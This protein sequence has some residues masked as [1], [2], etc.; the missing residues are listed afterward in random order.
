MIFDFYIKDNKIDGLKSVSRYFIET[1]LIIE[2]F[3]NSKIV[4]RQI[5]LCFIGRQQCKKQQEIIHC[6]IPLEY[7]DDDSK[8]YMIKNKY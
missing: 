2:S 3:L 7:F 5:E 1:E 6:R 4:D 8:V